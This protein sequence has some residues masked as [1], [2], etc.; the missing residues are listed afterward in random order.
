MTN[1]ESLKKSLKNLEVDYFLLPNSDEF[2]SEYLPKYA[3]RLQFL[4]GFSGSNAFVIISQGKS[5]FFTDGRY[6][7]QADSQVNKDDFD[8][9]NLSDKSPLSWLL[10]NVEK[11]KIGFDPK[12]HT[13][14]QIHHFQ[15]YFGENLV[16]LEE[17]PIDEIWKNQPESPKTKV[18]DH[19]IQYS[20]ESSES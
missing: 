4:T 6:T 2:N 20:G 19:E 8:I 17:N 5:A 1:I 18:F 16:A 14:N 11:G 3:Q 9:F 10:D 15:K 13:I 7:L 12:I